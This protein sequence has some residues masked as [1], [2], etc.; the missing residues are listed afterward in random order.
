MIGFFQRAGFAEQTL[1][2]LGGT[3]PPHGTRLSLSTMPPHHTTTVVCTDSKL[4]S[5]P[6]HRFQ[7]QTYLYA[8]GN[9][10]VMKLERETEYNFYFQKKV[11]VWHA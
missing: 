5:K 3:T 10:S 9:S 2:I 1:L 7:D 4:T 8:N 6:I 11:G